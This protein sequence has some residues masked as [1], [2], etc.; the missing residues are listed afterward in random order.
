MP[1]RQGCARQWLQD[2]KLKKNRVPVAAAVYFDDRYVHREFSEALVD[3]LLQMVWG[4]VWLSC[5]PSPPIDFDS[6]ITRSKSIWRKRREID[7]WIA[8][9]DCCRDDSRRHARKCQAEMLVTKSKKQVSAVWHA[10]EHRQVIR[11]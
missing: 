4:E 3:R 7:S 11:Q 1:Q 8:A 6:G 9:H 5:S 2:E 10:S